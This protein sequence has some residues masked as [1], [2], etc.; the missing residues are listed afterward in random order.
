[1]AW[2]S[3]LSLQGWDSVDECEGLLRVITIGPCELNGQR[4]SAPVAD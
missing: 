2:V 4:N 3:P 1:M